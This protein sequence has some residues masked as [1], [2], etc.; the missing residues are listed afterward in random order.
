MRTA[1]KKDMQPVR[2]KT[3]TFRDAVVNDVKRA[4]LKDHGGSSNISIM[5]GLNKD[6]VRDQVFLMTINGE[7]A[8]IDLEELLSYTRLI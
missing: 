7:K 8:Y 3:T 1:I 2:E 5:W 4:D 6:S